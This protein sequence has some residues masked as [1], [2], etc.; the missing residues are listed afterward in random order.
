MPS[1][2]KQL[3]NKEG[4]DEHF[5]EFN[6]RLLQ[7]CRAA[8]AHA[9]T[10]ICTHLILRGTKQVVP[11]SMKREPSD[12][13][14]VGTDHLDTVTPSD[15][16]HT[17][18]AVWRCREDH[19]LKQKKKKNKCEDKRHDWVVARDEKNVLSWKQTWDGW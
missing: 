12:T 13:S 6:K 7:F 11:S 19:R 9:H 18:G 1:T 10:H 16:P 2:A 3:R 17:Y 5:G 14:L 4:K 8:H 15:R